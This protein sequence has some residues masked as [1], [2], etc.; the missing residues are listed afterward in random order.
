MWAQGNMELPAYIVEA[1]N[2]YTFG[3]SLKIATQQQVK[4]LQ[5][6]L[7]IFVTLRQ[8]S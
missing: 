6:L 3:F 5:Y 7:W 4:S 8:N 2:C 1:G